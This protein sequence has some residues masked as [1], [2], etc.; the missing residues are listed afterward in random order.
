M[1]KK[2]QKIIVIIMLLAMM[3]PSVAGV[4]LYFMN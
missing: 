4:L 1:S 3:I 2:T